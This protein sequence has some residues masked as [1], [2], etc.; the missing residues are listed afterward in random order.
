MSEQKLIDQ[1]KRYKTISKAL[2]LAEQWPQQQS[3]LG[4]L[5]KLSNQARM[6]LIR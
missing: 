2:M 4:Q 3:R 6:A 1:G 5:A